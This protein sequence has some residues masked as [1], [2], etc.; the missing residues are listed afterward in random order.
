MV[1][2]HNHVKLSVPGQIGQSRRSRV[3]DR[4]QRNIRLKLD[5]PWRADIPQDG[6]EAAKAELDAAE[7]I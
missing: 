6:D 2:G 1:V 7:A 3:A 4:F 5:R